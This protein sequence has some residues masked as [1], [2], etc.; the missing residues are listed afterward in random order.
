MFI[1]NK[2]FTNNTN[3]EISSFILVL[4]TVRFVTIIIVVKNTLW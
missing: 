1:N 2:G 3:L 4:T